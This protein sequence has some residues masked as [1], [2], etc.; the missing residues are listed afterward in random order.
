MLCGLT[1]LLPAPGHAASAYE[2]TGLA[3]WYGPHEAGRRTASGRIFNPT[4]LSAAHRTLPLG[5]CVRVTRPGN[6]KAIIVPVIDRGPYVHG[7]LLDL[8]RAAAEQLGMIRQGIARVRIVVAP[9][10]PPLLI[11][12][13]S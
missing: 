3:S 11:P 8:S 7:R 6:R 2:R 4:E 9:C 13:A 1:L 10:P 12:S 5:S